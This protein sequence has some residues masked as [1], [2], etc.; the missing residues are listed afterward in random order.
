VITSYEPGHGAG[1]SLALKRE[2]AVVER[3]SMVQRIL[4]LLLAL[5]CDGDELEL[6]CDQ[7]LP[8]V[9]DDGGP[10]PSYT[11]A[12]AQLSDCAQ[13]EGYY[14]RQRGACTDGKRFLSKGTGFVGDTLY[15]DGEVV[16]G[17]IPWSDFITCDVWRYGETR[18]EQIDV[19]EINCPWADAGAQ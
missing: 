16:I 8:A 12:S 17:R 11:A 1:H 5:G 19:E 18:C 3:G 13:L 7:P 10:W 6:D 15:F 4:L 14:S 2:R 9:D